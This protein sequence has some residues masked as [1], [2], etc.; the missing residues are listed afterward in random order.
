MA[1]KV[2]KNCVLHLKE[3]SYLEFKEQGPEDV[4]RLHPLKAKAFL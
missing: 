1:F 2:G 3:C 4:R